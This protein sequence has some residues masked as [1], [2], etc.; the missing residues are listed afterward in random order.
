[1]RPLLRR[2]IRPTEF[3]LPCT[4]EHFRDFPFFVHSRYNIR[5][6]RISPS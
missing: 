3:R 1:M 6:V 4:A 5:S 2:D